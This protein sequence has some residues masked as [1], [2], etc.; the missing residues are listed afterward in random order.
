MRQHPLPPPPCY[1]DF[2][3]SISDGKREFDTEEDLIECFEN[4]V[5]EV[6][7]YHLEYPDIGYAPILRYV[8]KVYLIEDAVI[9]FEHIT[10]AMRCASRQMKIEFLATTK[11]TDIFR[12]GFTNSVRKD[13]EGYL[14]ITDVLFK[15]GGEL[16]EIYYFGEPEEFRDN[17]GE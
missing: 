13:I 11:D 15:I 3:K 5:K 2:I 6:Y 17:E 8:F 10:D 1:W 14:T 7:Q 9:Y 4:Y 16:R 12:L